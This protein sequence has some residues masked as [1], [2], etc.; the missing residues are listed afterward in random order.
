MLTLDNIT[1]K[2]EDRVLFEN[3]GYTVG[4]YNIIQIKGE[5]GAGKSTLLKIIAGIFQ[6]DEGQVLYALEKIK[7][8]HYAEYCD[9]FQYLGHKLGLKSNLTVY[10]NIEFWAKLKNCE[11]M[12]D[13]A[14]EY[15]ELTPHKN[16]RVNQLS[17]GLQ[18]RVA[19]SK[20]M[21]CHCEMWLLDE[22]YVNLDDRGK[23]LLSELIKVRCR[24]GG[25]AIIASHEDINI[26]NTQ[27]I[28]IAD[29]QPNKA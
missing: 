22:P 21:C 4:D 15:F 23:T 18:K 2:R 8:E 29:F 13:A 12:I 25:V 19:L 9:I 11:L 10:E 24:E 6:P 7:G 27:I 20:V 14:I 17:A 3:L 1:A 16:K 5:N 28:D 26:E